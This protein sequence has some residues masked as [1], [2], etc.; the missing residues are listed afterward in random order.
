MAYA[1]A[2]A[3]EMI[4]DALV[5][6]RSSR[7]RVL[8]DVGSGGCV[9]CKRLHRFIEQDSEIR[10]LVERSFLTVRV[11]LR[12]NAAMLSA[13]APVPGTPHYFVLGEDGSLLHSQ[14][15]EILESGQSYNRGRLLAFFKAW[16]P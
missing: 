12:A 5:R 1:T 13:Y 11:D 14:G 15:T 8:I 4:Q 16:A 7:K 10:E 2:G 9:W 6:A 3:G